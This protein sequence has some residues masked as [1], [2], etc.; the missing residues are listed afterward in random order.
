MYVCANIMYVC[1]YPCMAICMYMYIYM[2]ALIEMVGG[3]CPW[4]NM[5]Y[6]KLGELSQ[7]ET[8]P[9]ESVRGKSVQRKTI[10]VHEQTTMHIIPKYKSLNLSQILI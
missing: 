3:N 4:E 6:S 1:M 7:G 10:R 5:S 8:V 9:G 2:Y